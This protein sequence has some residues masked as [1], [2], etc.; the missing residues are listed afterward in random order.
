MTVRKVLECG[1]YW[2]SLFR[3]SYS[4]CKS[5]LHIQKLHLLSCQMTIWYGT[6][7]HHNLYH[8]EMATASASGCTNDVCFSP[9]CPKIRTMPLAVKNG[10]STDMSGILT[11]ICNHSFHCSCISKWAD[12]S[13]PVCRYCKQQPKKSICFVC[14]TSENLWICVICGFVGCGRYEGHSIRHWKE[15]QHCYSLELEMQQVWDYAGHNYL[16]HYCAHTDDG[17][18]S[19][20]CSIDTGFSE[21]LLN[22]KVEN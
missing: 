13:C 22:S 4:F 11:T 8:E 19:C 5:S 12:S 14:Q 15:T 21:T 20:N 18:G 7:Y 1:F 3:D 16:N 10:V 6:N 2:P 17:C 9:T